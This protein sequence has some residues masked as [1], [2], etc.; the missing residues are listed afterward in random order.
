MT[1]TFD[2][3]AIHV[4]TRTALE[5]L[6]ARA[7]A[8]GAPQLPLFRAA[9]DGVIALAF[10]HDRSAAWPRRMVEG[11]R[12]PLVL[13]VGDDPGPGALSLGPRAWTC[14]RRLRDWIGAHGAVIV[15]GGSGQPEHYRQAVIA[16]AV[17]QRVAV[18]ECGSDQAQ[19]WVKFM[20]CP[21]TLLI[22]PSDGQHPATPT[23]N[24]M[25]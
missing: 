1:T 21:Q 15:H 22:L 17:V 11:S 18:I 2:D 16:T 8:T 14:A 13:L 10:I 6:C 25:S 23:R 20:R 7:V 5:A 9:A 24:L 4:R 12:R 3:E 19:A